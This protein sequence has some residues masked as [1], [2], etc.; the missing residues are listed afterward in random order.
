MQS[1]RCWGT[2]PED[3]IKYKS[4]W[5]VASNPGVF[6]KL[7]YFIITRLTSLILNFQWGI[8]IWNGASRKPEDGVVWGLLVSNGDQLVF[9]RL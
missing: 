5:F 9:I 1:S 7:I 3:G 4:Y 6:F 2:G 8:T